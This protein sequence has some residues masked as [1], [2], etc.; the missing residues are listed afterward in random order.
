MVSRFSV[1]LLLGTLAAS[2]AVAED[3]FDDFSAEPAATSVSNAANVDDPWEGFNR[4]M[5]TFNEG[6]DK[7]ALK[8]AALGYRTVVP[9]AARSPIRRFYD[10]LRDFKSGLNNIL[11]WRWKDAGHNLGRFAVNSTL[12]VAGFFDVAT[13]TGLKRESSD[14]GITLARW[15]VPEG[16]YV[17]LPFLGP[18][19][20]R[21]A[22]TIY[23]ET[24][25]D[26]NF[27]DHRPTSWA[28]LGGRVLDIRTT[29][30]DYEEAIVGDRY[31]FVR[32]FYL[33]S[34]RAKAG[35]DTRDQDFDF[36]ADDDWDDDDW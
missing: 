29:L 23:P 17:M 14:L 10:N 5:F 32:E 22:T 2:S 21:D 34:R 16:P 25:F 27:V 24:Y 9:Q 31:N 11:Q 4:K 35:I 13:S 20:V 36:G 12:G 15:G 33:Q 28:I 18:S 26:L 8:P 19:T 1:V 30:L 6:V 3:A 7:Y